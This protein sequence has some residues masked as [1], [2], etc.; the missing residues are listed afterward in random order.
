MFIFIFKELHGPV[1]T[2]RSRPL[3]GLVYVRR[4][5]PGFS[6][7]FFLGRGQIE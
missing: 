7:M 2:R 6:V 4:D 3:V 5:C 1:T